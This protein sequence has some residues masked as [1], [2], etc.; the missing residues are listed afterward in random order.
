MHTR[1]Q[2]NGW[3]TALVF[4]LVPCV[5]G[6]GFAQSLRWTD[7]IWL[8]TAGGFWPVVLTAISVA[9]LIRLLFSD[10]DD[11]TSGTAAWLTLA[12]TWFYAPAWA[13]A[14][15]V[16]YAAAVVSSEGRAHNVRETARY[17]EY[18][19]WF[20]TDHPGTRIVHNVAGKIIATS[21]EVDYSYADPYV[22][23]RAHG[24]DLSKPLARA[25]ST[26]LSEEAK[27]TRASKIA[28]FEDRAGQDR[29]LARI[30]SAAVGDRTECP[31]KIKLTPQVDATGIGA[32]WSP[33][34]SEKEAIAERHLPTLV[35][36]LT[37]S[38][39]SIVAP[40][41]IFALLLEL[42]EGVAPLSQV[43]QNPYFLSDE[44]FDELIRRILNSPGCGDEAV[45]I[46]SK[47]NR[48][49]QTQRQELR[50]KA[51]GEAKISKIV[52]QAGPLRLTDADIAQLSPRM[53]AAFS[54]DPG[55]AVRTLEIFGERLPPET[56]RDAVSRIVRAKASY[57]LAALVHVN[58]SDDLRRELMKKVLADAVYEDFSAARLTKESL[59]S[60][61]IPAELKALIGKAIQESDTSKRWFEFALTSL[62]I[63]A[64]TLEERQSLLTGLM[65]ESPKAAIEFVSKNRAYLEPSEVNE[66]TRGYA[67]TV[68]TDFCL[69]LSHR[70]KNWRT[71]YFSEDQLQIFRECAERK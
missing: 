57:A 43:A 16:P 28:L 1:K 65:F 58:F 44:Q 52:A 60:A 56:Q 2:R 37:K 49:S 23:T 50:A 5:L 10:F 32:T 36:L 3:I 17:P 4:G 21:I 41:R 38:D 48:L 39:S 15:E 35:R 19:V 67:R 11:R 26:I 9:I 68:E 46:L 20:L 25:A 51:L 47:V 64:M 45:A 34:Y 54:A 63:S 59:Q 6:L 24:E 8:T 33:Y 42:A 61:L 55:V 30:C 13:T 71:D 27:R 62:P 14:I 12:C 31:L 40:D 53:R 29:V 7:T 18:K 69:H 66:V 70:N 22:A